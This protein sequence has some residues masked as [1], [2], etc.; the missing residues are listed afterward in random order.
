MNKIRVGIIR[1]DTHAVYYGALMEKHDPLVLRSPMEKLGKRKP[2]YGWETGAAYFYHYTNCYD[3]KKITVPTV[4]GFEIVKVWDEDSV[5]AT[6]LS[7]VFYGKPKV[8]KTFEEVSDDVDLVFISDSAGDGS[9]HLKLA[10]QGIK[11]GI[12]TFIDKPFAYEV[13]DARKLVS[14]AKKHNVPIMSLSMLRVLPH[15]T[16]FRDRFS[17]LNGPKFGIIKGHGLHIAGYIHTISLSQHLFGTGVKS[18]ECMGKTP[19]AYIHLDYGGKPDRPKS[20]VVLCCDAGP[21]YHCSMYASAYSEWGAIHSPNMGDYEFPWA[22]SIILKMIKKMV[23]TKKPQAS[24]EEM[25]ENIALAEAARIAQK[26]GKT[27]YLKDV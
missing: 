13:K 18:V 27:V 16:R 14:L 2:Y 12:P 24:Y 23:Q 9:D 26:T 4:S 17:E 10:T 5:L 1:C 8:C 11:K 6:G 20:G 15:A 21:T 19:L 3:A 25:I 22:A 7:E